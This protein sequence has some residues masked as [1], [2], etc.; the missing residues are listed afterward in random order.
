MNAPTFL[1][2]ALAMLFLGIVFASDAMRQYRAGITTGRGPKILRKTEPKQF[3][4][5]IIMSLVLPAVLIA[6]GTYFLIQE[7]K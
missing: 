3:L 7:F 1:P 5:M 6:T 2:I 4:F